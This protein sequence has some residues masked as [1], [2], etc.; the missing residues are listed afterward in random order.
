MMATGSSGGLHHG[1]ELGRERQARKRRRLSLIEQY[2]DRFAG[3]RPSQGA[4]Y[5]P[6]RLDL[7]VRRQRPALESAVP[8]EIGSVAGDAENGVS[9]HRRRAR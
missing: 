6:G 2:R 4:Q 5:L 8:H 1:L 3:G 7:D 9:R